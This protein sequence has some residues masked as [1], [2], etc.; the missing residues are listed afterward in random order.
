[1]KMMIFA[2]FVALAGPAFSAPAGREYIE[3]PPGRYTIALTGLVSTVC[4]RAVAA[5]WARLPEI[6]SATVDFD[7]SQASLTVR[8]NKTLKVSAL[9]K[10]LRRAEK[11]ANLGAHY[12]LF[13]ITYQLDK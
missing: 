4:G 10:S 6:E 2:L 3:L 1:M 7:K 9:R 12:D 13:G 11:L 8:L 5:E